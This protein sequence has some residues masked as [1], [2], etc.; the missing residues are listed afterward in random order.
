[1]DAIALNGSA[2][3]MR[4][5]Y[6]SLTINDLVCIDPPRAREL[7]LERVNYRDCLPL[8]NQILLEP[9]INHRNQYNA[10]TAYQGRLF[11]T[12][13][14]ALLPRLDG[15]TDVFW[16]YQVAIAAATVIKNCVE[17]SADQ[18][19][20][21]MF[22]TSRLLFYAQVKNVGDAT[23]VG[24]NLTASI[25]RR[26]DLLLPVNNANATLLVPKP[27]TATPAC[28]ISQ[29]PDQYLYP[30][31]IIDC[32]YLFYNILTNP[33]VERPI[34]LRG[35]SPIR[36]ESYG[37]CNLQLRGFSAVSADA[38]KFVELLFAAVNIVQTCVL[39]GRLELGGAVSVGSRGQ[40]YVRVFNP[41]EEEMGKAVESE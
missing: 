9:R 39:Q 35:L 32:Y 27:I 31:R 34:I 3:N 14:I 26:E 11:R 18:Y 20:G 15:G 23:T 5:T 38:F 2:F 1:M 8:L 37:T 6:P 10:T 33:V 24:E 22:T 17:D 40:Y 16:G 28:Q 19:G 13:S 25:L 41:L 30:V 29:P 21:L 36:Y 12:C 4:N 7:D